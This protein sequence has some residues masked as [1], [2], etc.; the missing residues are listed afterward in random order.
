MKTFKGPAPLLLVAVLPL[1]GCQADAEADPSGGPIAVE[2]SPE[3]NAAELPNPYSRMIYPW[4]EH[5]EGLDWGQ[6][7]AV[8]SANDGRTLWFADRC[9]AVNCIG[10]DRDVLF[11]LDQQGA[12][13]TAFG[14]QMFIRPHGLFVDEEDNVWLTDHQNARP[15]QIAENPAAAGVGQ[16]VFKFSPDG[17]I[18]LTL[19]TAGEA[20][21]PPERLNNPT[22]VIVG[23][24]GVIYVSEGH[25][26][27]RPPGRISMFGQD[28]SFI[29]SFGS[30]GAEEGQFRTPHG[31]A[32]DSR[33]RLY[34]ADR[35][36]SRIQVFDQSGTF[37]EELRQFGRPNDVLIDENDR[38]FS[39]DSES[40]EEDNPG[41]PRGIYVGDAISGEV[42]GFIPPHEM[43]GRPE[44]T[45]GEGI[46]LDADGNLYVAEVSM[47]GM[48]K[49]VNGGE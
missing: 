36:N 16:Q 47:R 23:P 5:P 29:G 7:S 4:S 37:I 15:E 38:L 25:S 19:G 41:Y 2:E 27:S 45:H 13:V 3:V 17:E 8:A 10:S 22:D 35:G 26:N 18:L 9:G 28:G 49:Y 20:G 1:A 33:G 34:V 40:G 11:E 43:E 39:I 6:V 14:A 44:G 24:N 32:F 12:V 30:F 21:D 48:T 42:T 46:A 31:L